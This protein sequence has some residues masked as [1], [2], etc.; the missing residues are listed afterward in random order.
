MSLK[1]YKIVDEG[2]KHYIVEHF[3]GSKFTVAHEGLDKSTHDKIRKFA[4]GGL[5]ADTTELPSAEDPGNMDPNSPVREVGQSSMAFS[6]DEAPPVTAPPQG[7]AQESDKVAMQQPQQAQALSTPSKAMQDRKEGIALEAKGAQQAAKGSAE[8]FK[9]QID[10]AKALQL[11]YNQ[12][13]QT[14]QSERTKLEKDIVDQKIDPNRFWNNMSTGN[15]ILAGL[16]ILL[17]SNSNGDNQALKIIQGKM[18]KDLQAQTL[19]LDKKK[20][21]LSMN[22]QKS[23]DL[24]QAMLMTRD[25]Q[26]SA[27][28]AQLGMVASQSQNAIIQGKAKQALAMVDQQQAQLDAQLSI[29]RAQA[30]AVTGGVDTNQENVNLL[31]DKDYRAKRV[32]VGNTAYQAATPI[33]AKEVREMQSSAEPFREIINKMSQLGTGALI[34]GSRENLKAD[35]L[36]SQ[37]IMHLKTIEKLGVLSATDVKLVEDQLNDPRKLKNILNGEAKSL[38]VLS[39]LD[40][41]L[42]EAYKTKLTGYKGKVKA[43]PGFK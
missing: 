36:K 31:M 2:K 3:D 6:E 14:I 11:D 18:D 13:R 25:N 38:E 17:G 8:A 21:L 20:N 10:Q 5:V 30:Q 26:L 37:A 42:E 1:D 39:N 35:A 9:G 29:L 23:G 43:N 41:K 12:Q 19:E 7:V 32:K 27:I 33:E 4:D 22:Y 28:K 24:N 15:Q 40:N 34:S 16:S